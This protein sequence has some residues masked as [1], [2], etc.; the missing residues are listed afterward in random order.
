MHVMVDH[1]QIEGGAAVLEAAEQLR[2]LCETLP[3]SSASTLIELLDR[4][5]QAATKSDCD[6]DFPLHRLCS[7][8][9]LTDEL[10][11]IF[12]KRCPDAVR[13]HSVQP[14][15]EFEMAEESS[16]EHGEGT[17]K[18]FGDLP[19][20]R[21]C[22]NE[23]LSA[24]MLHQLLELYPESGLI[25]SSVGE[26]PLQVLCT[27]PSLSPSLLQSFLALSP[28]SA[29]RAD[30]RGLLPLHC[31]CSP[32]NVNLTLEML[33]TLIHIYPEAAQICDGDYQYTPL[34]FLCMHEKIS[35]EMLAA[36]LDA[37]PESAKFA[38]DAGGE[39]GAVPL[40]MLCS[41]SAV[42]EDMLKLLLQHNEEA[43]LTGCHDYN[44]LGRATLPLHNL[45]G[46]RS[47]SRSMLTMIL[48]SNPKG[49][50]SRD[51]SGDFPL[52]RLCENEFLSEE[53]L[54]AFLHRCPD[55]AKLKSDVLEN[56]WAIDD[57]GHPC[58]D[59][60][61]H[62]L[63]RNKKM[64]LSMLQNLLDLH[65][66]A[67][68]ERDA[69]GQYP[70][71]LYLHRNPTYSA[72][73]ELLQVSPAGAEQEY[74]KH[75]QD[76]SADACVT[77]GTLRLT[78]LDLEGNSAK[79]QFGSTD[80]TRT[81]IISGITE[82]FWTWVNGKHTINI[83]SQGDIQMPALES[84]DSYFSLSGLTI[85]EEG[86]TLDVLQLLDE[87]LPRV[88]VEIIRLHDEVATLKASTLANSFEVE[89]SQQMTWRQVAA[90]ISRLEA[91]PVCPCA[92]DGCCRRASETVH[93]T[94]LRS[95]EL[96]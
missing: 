70:L 57:K 7:N 91:R 75:S 24:V 44:T 48:D 76:F 94:W 5:P 35:T 81:V 82:E 23:S 63:C 52:H 92:K 19:L 55:A 3:E 65:P 53:M 29:R 4:Q 22:G 95:A 25:K 64:T 79:L 27:N 8:R 66:E 68:Q 60:P 62:R 2:D 88:V 41:N 12:L 56:D 13:L 46:N 39:H 86:P 78:L 1:S 11:N 42:T 90:E 34:H 14:A 17:E 33:Y 43:P 49:F 73:V 10:L 84:S 96:A 32:L 38:G 85:E 54:L 26:L 77:D 18:E 69:S 59:L 28:E 21:L 20:H 40:H 31:T 58:G 45:C 93:E 83:T 47:I 37:N 71:C 89:L 61:L 36:V 67:A 51:I 72:V 50:A 15:D 80:S 16:E 87:C 6:G 30:F 9:G 74:L